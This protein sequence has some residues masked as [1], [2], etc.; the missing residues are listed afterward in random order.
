MQ[1]KRLV[2]FA[3]GKGTTL[4][5]ILE[6]CRDSVLDASIEI[7]V[8]DKPDCPAVEIARNNQ[9]QVIVLDAGTMDSF[10]GGLSNLD[11]EN[12]ADLIVLAGF[13]R[14][15]PDD[16]VDKY[17]GRMINTHPALLP[18]FGGKGMYGARV[19]RAVIQSGARIS[20][21]SVHFV[22][23]EVDGGPIIAQK[24]VQVLDSDTAETLAER[25]KATEKEVLIESIGYILSGKYRIDGKR[26]IPLEIDLSRGKQDF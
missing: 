13:N 7:L 15:L 6:A 20:G 16:F 4:Q 5:A 14:I 9:I 23:R 8:S 17:G 10:A 18:C 24:A 3:S 21:C 19:H 12:K 25:V 2:V 26:V 1:K 11:I 22:S